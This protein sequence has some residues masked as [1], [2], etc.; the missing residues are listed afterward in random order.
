[1]FSRFCNEDR[2]EIGDIDI[3]V[4]PD[5]REKVYNYIINRFGEEYTAFILAIGTVSEKG[6]ID[7]IV[8]ALAIRW[9][10]QNLR[11]KE[12]KA[13]KAQIT[14]LRQEDANDEIIRLTEELTKLK[15]QNEK[16]SE[17]NPWIRK[18][19]E[20]KKEYDAD[21][22]TARQKYSE[23]FYYFDGLLNTA[24]TQ[25]IHPAGIV[26][27]PLTLDDNYGR[28]ES[29][30]KVILQIDM[31]CIHEVSLVKY[32]ILGLKNIQIIKDAYKLLGKPYP[33]S[34]EIDWFDS[35]VWDDMLKSPVGIFQF[36]GDFAHQMLRRY[37]PKSIFDMSLVTAALR[38]SGASYRNQLM[39]HITNKNPSPIIDELLKDNNGYLV[40]QEDVIKFLQ[41]ICG[42]SGSDADNTRRAIARKEEERMR[43]ALPLILEGYCSKSTQP[44]NVAE[45]EAKAFLKIIED[46]SSYMFGL[47][48]SVGYCMIGYLCAYL[49]YY[50]PHEF[51]SAYLNNA[52]DEDDT[53]NGSELAGLY[54]IM[55][56]PPKFGL[57]KDKYI[58][59]KE[60]GVIAKGISS[61][62]YMNTG[63]A[64]ELYELATTNKPKSFMELLSVISSNTSVD[65]RQRDI[66]IKIDYFSEYGNS[67]ELLKISEMFAFFKNGDMKI[68][69]KSKLQG[70][71]YDIVRAYSND[72]NK[73]GEELKS[74]TILDM[75]SILIACENYIKAQRIPDFDLNSKI[76]TQLEFMGYVDLTTDDKNDRRKLLI[77][78]VYPLKSKSNGLPWGY[79]LSTRSIG[80]GKTARL[81][82]RANIYQ[83]SPIKRYDT[84]YAISVIRDAK[85]YWNLQDYEM[86][87]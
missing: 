74:F 85:G 76:Q 16:A 79:A 83:Q 63:A 5:D 65:T 44:R 47:N 30:G 71:L 1:M 45:E 26:A 38:P 69:N 58:F 21:P 10:S 17:K 54:N 32:D 43:K 73:K 29:D 87:V 78:D 12:E 72:K 31:E 77:M 50:Y 18:S 3:D 62:K 27:S 35:K 37:K 46:A 6:T 11:L 81:T 20:I 42:F 40:Y 2:K 15:A 52:K 28:F 59:D 84:I 86:V 55:I 8:R 60:K 25:S 49:R 48:H 34:H 33:L 24:I 9:D 22:K 67:M 14:K 36:E 57:S 39:Q 41:E 64:N 13:I 53:K 56:V 61:I 19:A 4:A 23:V 82:V 66:L 7:E 80:T 68:V 75:M 70:D 51:I